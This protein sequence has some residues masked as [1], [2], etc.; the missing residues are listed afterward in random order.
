M[1]PI[2]D[3]KVFAWENVEKGTWIDSTFLRLY[4]DRGL[5]IHVDEG[6]IGSLEIP[7]VSLR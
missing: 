7:V 1:L 6:K 2:V 3:Y 5:T 4:E